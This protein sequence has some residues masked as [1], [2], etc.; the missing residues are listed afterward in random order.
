MANDELQ[1]ILYLAAFLGLP[2]FVITEFVAAGSSSETDPWTQVAL[3]STTV[4]LMVVIAL[5]A[6][7]CSEA[8]VFI[9]WLLRQA[10]DVPL[11]GD[12]ALR[13]S[14]LQNIVQVVVP[15]D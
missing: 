8:Y 4:M 7:A 13:S 9:A 3:C 11:W 10:W 12:E 1:L 15:T 14:P 6:L 5:F 2:S